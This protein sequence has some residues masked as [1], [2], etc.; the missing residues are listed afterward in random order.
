[1]KWLE[2]SGVIELQ[3]TDS[4]YTAH[5]SIVNESLAALTPY[6]C[7]L[8]DRER[9]YYEAL[10][11]DLRRSSYLLGRLAAKTAV[12]TA[13]GKQV[14]DMA[15]FYIGFGVFK[16]PVVKHC[17]H[18]NMQ[19]SISHCDDIGIALAFPEEHPWVLIWKG[20][21][22]IKRRLY[23]QYLPRLIMHNC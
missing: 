17:F 8:H 15:A 6:L 11:V 5:Y 16:F 20:W 21:M 22:P 4:S 19:V 23:R 12:S 10:K 18:S 1:M 3:R 9:N 7:L 13:S 2:N 14:T